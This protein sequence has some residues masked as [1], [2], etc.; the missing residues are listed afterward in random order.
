MFDLDHPKSALK[1]A[2]AKR[3]NG[4][5]K[6][7]LILAIVFILTIAVSHGPWATNMLYLRKVI[8][9]TERELGVYYSVWCII[10]ALTHYIAIPFLSGY[11]HL[12]DTTI[13]VLGILGCIA[14][15]VS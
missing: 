6:Y 5:R 4:L 13:G 10:G 2:F 9:W 7:V 15:T 12:H 11:L 8:K 3:P 1:T 14:N